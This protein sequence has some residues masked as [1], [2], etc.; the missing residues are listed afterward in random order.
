M[1]TLGI[2]L[3]DP[4]SGGNFEV[5]TIWPGALEEDQLSYIQ[6]IQRFGHGLIIGIAFGAY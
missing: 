3:V 6:G 2:E 1:D 5:V 4:V